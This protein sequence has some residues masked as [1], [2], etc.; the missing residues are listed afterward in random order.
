[1]GLYSDGKVGDSYSGYD[2][3][4]ALEACQTESEYGVG[5]LTRIMDD[6]WKMDY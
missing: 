3:D 1:M 6:G 4:W 5:C 2:Y